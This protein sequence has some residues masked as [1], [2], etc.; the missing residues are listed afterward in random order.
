M[1]IRIQNGEILNFGTFAAAA[2][3]T[4]ARV[5]RS[6]STTM[7][8]KALTTPRSIAINGSAQ[9]AIGEIDLVYPKN[10]MNDAGMK[11]M[12]DY[13]FARS[14]VVELM[15]S[16]SVVVAVTG[17]SNQSSTSWTSSIESD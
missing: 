4:H 1:A 16:S 10:D 7:V 15:T 11:D 3:V 13:H 14:Q 8:T 6:G 2:R 9:F 12:L 5:G 17:Y